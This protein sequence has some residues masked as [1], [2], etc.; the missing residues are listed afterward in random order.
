MEEI[1]F[2]PSCLKYDIEEKIITVSCGSWSLTTIY[3][4]IKDESVLQ[5]G[6]NKIWLLNAAILVE[7]NAVLHIN[8]TDTL[9]LKIVPESATTAANGIVVHGTLKIGSTKIT[10]WNPVVE[11]YVRFDYD[12]LPSKELENTGIDEISRPYITISEGASGTM[13]IEDSELAYLGY[14]CKSSSFSRGCSGL[15]YYGGDGS[16]IKGNHIHHNRFGFYSDG[17]SNM[18]LEDNNVHHNF[19][20]G[21][22][23]H[24]GTHD[25]IIKNNTVHDN[26][27]M[28]I[29]CSLDCYNLAI[30]DNKVYN[31]T[32]SGIMFSRNMTNSIA[33]NNNVQDETQCIFV[34]QS[35][36]NDFYSN[37][38]SNCENAGIYLRKHS[39]NNEIYNNTIVD[40]KKGVLVNTGS[41]GNEFRFNTIINAE[42]K[43][44]SVRTNAGENT[45]T[46]NELKNSP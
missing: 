9:W 6:G 33:S 4:S 21:L 45:F 20:Y 38:V 24:T 2:L 15:N 25:M 43:G 16:V 14:S 26:G 31:N 7:R 18:I 23:P 5:K 39:S 42:E 1:R 12:I 40:S 46:K 19:M 35:H 28:G 41:S 32:G 30:Q 17:V 37:T 29:I 34:S 13:D 3:S 11:D 22:D 44:I 8:S 10:S 27:S 36:N